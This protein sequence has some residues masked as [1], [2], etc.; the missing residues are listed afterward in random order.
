[1]F[2]VTLGGLNY[3]GA[4]LSAK[5]GKQHVQD[6]CHSAFYGMRDV[7][8]YAGGLAGLYLENRITTS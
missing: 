2:S 8:L 6:P 7:C 1:M 5:C 4:T 3:L